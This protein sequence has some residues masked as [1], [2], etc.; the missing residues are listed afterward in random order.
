MAVGAAAMVFS[1]WRK[2]PVS[3]T[4]YHLTWAIF[5]S[6]LVGCWLT[7]GVWGYPTW[8]SWHQVCF[9]VSAH[10]LEIG[11]VAWLLRCDDPQP[12]SAPHAASASTTA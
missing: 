11:K 7:V 5:V 10:F 12:A 1:W 9:F 4:T 6:G 8:N 3:R 2:F